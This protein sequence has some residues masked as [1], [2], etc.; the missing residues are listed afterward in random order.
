MVRFYEPREVPEAHLHA[1]LDLARKAPSAGHSQGV[2]FAVVRAAEKR[3]EI[4]RAYGE[5]EFL[6]RGFKPWLSVAPV[7]LIVAVDE[8]SY[9]ERYSRPDKKTDPSKW[10]IP[11]PILDAGQALMTLYLAARR[12]GL[13]TGFLG[14][15]AG[16]DLVVKMGLPASW[17]YVGLVTVGYPAGPSG[18]TGSK[19]RG[20]RAYEETVLWLD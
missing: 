2:R 17:R 4:A 5:D 14:S 8:G 12:F 1:I 11:Y 16:P 7:H 18:S 15:H 19:R 10:S 3:M 6:A 20:W 9:R 13:G